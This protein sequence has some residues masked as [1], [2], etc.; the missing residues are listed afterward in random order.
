M[1]PEEKELFAALEKELTTRM[2][3]SKR[4][5]IAVAYTP[6]RMVV[7]TLLIL[8]GIAGLITS[9]AFSTTI[10][11]LAAFVIMFMGGYVLSTAVF[12]PHAE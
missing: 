3:T 10:G 5:L 11:G 12:L 8:L 6:R 4:S 9:V 2:I 1:N 7:G